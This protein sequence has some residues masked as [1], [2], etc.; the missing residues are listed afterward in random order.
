[1]SDMKKEIIKFES[2]YIH[3]AAAIVGSKEN[4]G[5]LGGLFDGFSSDD[6]FNT[7]TW[8]KAE[9]E[10]V[11]LSLNAL[12]N[13]SNIDLSNVD[14]ITGGDL[15]DQCIATSHAMNNNGVPYFG[16]YGAC[17]TAAES[18]IIGGM[19][20]DKGFTA[21]AVASS[22]FCSAERQ[23]RFPLEYGSQRTP[24][25]QNTV[26]GCGT[27]LL[28]RERSN[29]RVVEGVAGKVQDNG[30]D[31]A[32]NMG[33]AMAT[34]AVDTLMRYFNA[35]GKSEKDFDIIAT[36]DLGHEGYAL[37]KEYAKSYG[38]ILRDNF[39][40]C[41][42]LIYDVNTQNVGAGGSGCGCSATVF[43]AEIYPKLKSGEYKNALLIGTGALL[44]QK[45]IIQNKIIPSVAHLVCFE[46]GAKS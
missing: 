12:L 29:V 35:S 11:K 26:T 18:I 4:Q 13:K 10:M 31:D 40:D 19:L 23:Y 33:A 15:L 6:R 8:E 42:M 27:L 24:T 3:G 37:A 46:G 44:S 5:P 17:S 14:I 43:A 39:T 1:M 34:A 21:A 2:V 32:N 28:K 38:L 30:I 25:A 41:G 36:G 9:T 7:D 20:A 22:H 16:L 45:S